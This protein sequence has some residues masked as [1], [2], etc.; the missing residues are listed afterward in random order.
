MNDAFKELGH[1]VTMYCEV[2]N[3]L[4]KLQILKKA[5]FLINLLVQQVQG[6]LCFVCHYEKHIHVIYR[7][8]IQ[9]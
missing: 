4:T 7:D 8:F 2:E 1:L 9:L 3:N 6:M 5:I